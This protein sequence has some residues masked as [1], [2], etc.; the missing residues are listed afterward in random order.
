[1]R[2]EFPSGCTV[3]RAYNDGDEA[4]LIA[5]FAYATD[6]EEFAKAKISE[7]AAR[8]WKGCHYLVANSFDGRVKIFRHKKADEEAKAA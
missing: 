8:N 6:A 1:M 2:A 4:E 5:L 3:S 7:D